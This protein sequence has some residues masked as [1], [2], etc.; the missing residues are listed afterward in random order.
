MARSRVKTKDID[1]GYKRILR[2][3]KK[4]EKKPHVK[5]GFPIERKKTGE[6]KEG[7]E[8]VT[9]LDVA[10]WHEFGT[11][12][13]PERSFVRSSFDKNVSKYNQMTRKQ[14]LTIFQN[15]T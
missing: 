15:R 8:F 3:L 14:N 7:N 10:I 2:E 9:V 4:L 13:L 11:V 1:H 6:P 5:V 12:G